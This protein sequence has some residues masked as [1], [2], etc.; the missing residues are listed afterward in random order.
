M[1]IATVVGLCLWCLI[2]CGQASAETITGAHIQDQCEKTSNGTE[3]FSNGFCAGFIDGVLEAQVM[4][5]VF[6]SK[7]SVGTLKR[8]PQLSFCLPAEVT[9]GQVV[10]IFTKYL[11]D[12]PEELHEPAA[13][14]L[15]T[16]LRKAF[17]C[18]K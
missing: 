3:P 7:G 10:K 17:P 16:S 15:V 5:E 12:H 6:E 8:N 11:D 14:L 2:A 4:W 18:G 13:L 9:N 1:K